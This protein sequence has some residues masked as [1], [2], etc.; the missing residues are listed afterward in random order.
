MRIS[1]SIK[2]IAKTVVVTKGFYTGY[3]YFSIL[4]RETLKITHGTMKFKHLYMDP[5][6][7]TWVN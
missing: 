3:Q 4:N 5:T 7:I 1:K 6:T 2:F